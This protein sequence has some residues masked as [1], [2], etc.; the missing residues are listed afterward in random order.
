M[1]HQT[2]KTMKSVAFS[3]L[4]LTIFLVG[5]TSLVF[6]QPKNTKFGKVSDEIVRMETFEAD[7]DAEAVMLYNYGQAVMEVVNNEIVL[8]YQFHKRI[9]I[10]SESGFSWANMS[11]LYRKGNHAD[12]VNNIQA[13]T[14]N[15]G[16]DG[17]V[18]RTKISNSDIFDEKVNGSL[19]KKK[20]SFPQ[21]KVGSVIEVKY[22]IT[23]EY[24]TSLKP[25]YFQQTIPVVYSEFYTRISDWY[26][27]A[28]AIWRRTSID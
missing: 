18:V 12:K 4:L 1:L 23:S 6:A 26:D 10:L 28:T 3:T 20:F 8:V 14:Y 15:I 24:F 13:I 27:Y 25:F 7:P 21:V 11:F 5:S 22:K 17:K 9:K 16:E 2:L 19:Y